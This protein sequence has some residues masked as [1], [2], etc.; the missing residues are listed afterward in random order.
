MVRYVRTL[1]TL[2]IQAKGGKMI[3]KQFIVTMI[4]DEKT[5]AQ[6][7][8]NF[9]INYNSVDEYIYREMECLENKY[10]G[11]LSVEEGLKMWGES[12][13]VE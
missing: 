12:I 7:N 6:K 8:T 13:K 5:I 2:I 4:V 10:E 11:E 9:S 3:K 1:Q